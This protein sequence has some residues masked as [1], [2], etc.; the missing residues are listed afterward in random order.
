VA[1][2]R[3]FQMRSLPSK[4]PVETSHTPKRAASRIS[5]I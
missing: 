3:L 1:A 4:S 5:S 2:S